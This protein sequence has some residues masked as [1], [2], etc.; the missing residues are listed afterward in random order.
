[1]IVM[2]LNQNGTN[3]YKMINSTVFLMSVPSLNQHL[4]SH[5]QLYGACQ[6]LAARCHVSNW[7]MHI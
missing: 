1:M 6:Y 7:K 3:Y 5:T 4:S 2:C